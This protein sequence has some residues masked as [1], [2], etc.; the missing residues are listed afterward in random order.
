M[1]DEVMKEGEQPKTEKTDAETVGRPKKVVFVAGLPRAGSTVLLNILAQNPRFHAT[2]TSGIL[3]MIAT[4]RNVWTKDETFKAAP[5]KENDI[6]REHVLQGMLYSY[7]QHVEEPVCLDKSRGWLGFAEMAEKIVGERPKFL[8]P[9]RDLCD[10]CAS[11]EKIYRRASS[12][13]QIAQENQHYVAMQSAIGRASVVMRTDQPMGIAKIRIEDAV[14]RGFRDCMYFVEYDRMCEQPDRVFEEIY[15]FI[16]ETEFKHD[17]NN[18][19]QVTE[20]NDDYHMWGK[21]LHKIRAKLEPQ[22][23]AWKKV[24]PRHV[25]KSDFWKQIEH[26]ATF[27]NNLRG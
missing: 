18:I 27:W 21:D 3:G 4:I 19:E 12:D 15:E 23:E 17:F 1:G 6:Q 14:V 25:T 16:D 26:E 20:E 5:E 22:P 9:V 24:Y 7:F 13:R 2:A 8:V 10:V 11:F